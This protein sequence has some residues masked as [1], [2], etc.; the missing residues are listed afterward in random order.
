V[1]AGPLD[2][3]LAR[4]RDERDFLLSS[5]EDLEVERAA[6][7]IAEEDYTRLRS[8]YV[9]RAAATLRRITELEESAPAP[10]P[11]RGPGSLQRLRRFL[12]RR[13]T[14][15]VLGTIGIVCACGIVA[16]TAAHFAGVR[17]PGEVATGSI[18]LPGAANLQSELADAATL[19]DE[20]HL[21]Q[22]ISLYD[23]ILR[24]DPRQ[25]QALAYRGWVLRLTGV[26]GH[27]KALVLAGDAGLAAAVRI[28][29]ASAPARAL[30]GVALFEDE[31]RTAAALG[32]FRAALGDH[33]SH[34]LLRLAGPTM[35]AA[36]VQEHAALP[37]SLAAYRP[38]P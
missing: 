4:L 9:A 24:A 34:Q 15:R 21:R 30:Y 19:D 37:P 17:L 2:E 35:A 20:G 16:I 38:R 12:G 23:T 18:E 5:I 10:A 36:F 25:P 6:G 14:R 26:A 32:E 13:R 27:V 29:P 33:P 8:G 11:P 22:A 3:R 7:D 28:D 31:G 1:G